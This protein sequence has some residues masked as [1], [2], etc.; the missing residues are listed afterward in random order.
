MDKE[1]RRSTIQLLAQV[2][3][4]SQSNNASDA[5][6]QQVRDLVTTILDTDASNIDTKNQGREIL[7]V[8][9]QIDEKD[10]VRTNTR[11]LSKAVATIVTYPYIRAKVLLQRAR[12]PTDERGYDATTAPGVLRQVA[13]R[14]GWVGLYRGLQPQLVK[15]VSNAALMLMIKERIGGAVRKR[16]LG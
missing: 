9:E 1:Q 13:A 11:S 16:I 3:A 15:G 2:C 5:E 10:A 4:A 14:E 6:R 7:T 12:D 8:I